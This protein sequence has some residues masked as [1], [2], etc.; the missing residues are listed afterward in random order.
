MDQDLVVVVCSEIKV[1][2]SPPTLECFD[3]N[4]KS[5]TRTIVILQYQTIEYHLYC[6]LEIIEPRLHV[7]MH[8]DNM[9]SLFHTSFTCGWLTCDLRVS[10]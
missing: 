10:M 4:K 3:E 1:M 8:C 5:Q 9:D 7:I 2:T 6:Y